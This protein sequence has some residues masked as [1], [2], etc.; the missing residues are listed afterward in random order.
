MLNRIAKKEIHLN[1]KTTIKANLIEGSQ[2]K[3]DLAE[4]CHNTRSNLNKF[5]KIKDNS[6]KVYRY[7]KGTV[8]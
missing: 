5:A 2:T 4:G 7:L 1:R 6:T 8:A 3:D